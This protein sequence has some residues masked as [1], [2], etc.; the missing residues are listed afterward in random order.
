MRRCLVSH[1]KRKQLKQHAKESVVF[2]NALL[3]VHMEVYQSQSQKGQQSFDAKMVSDK[4]RGGR[5]IKP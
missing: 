2:I 3:H 1:V 4:G 5:T